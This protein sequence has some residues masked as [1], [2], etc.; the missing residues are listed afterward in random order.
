[1]RELV[2][3]REVTDAE[4]CE[5]IRKVHTKHSYTLDPHGAVG[6][7]ALENF[8]ERNSQYSGVLLETA[9]PAKFKSTV[10]EATSEP[11]N[12]PP[13]LAAVLEKEKLAR[14]MGS[15]FEEFKQLL[16]SLQ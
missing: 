12:M 1:M 11:V 2:S 8:L 9:H 15:S 6:Y 7:L 14:P 13:R 4:T 3:S 10:E 16:L 5:T